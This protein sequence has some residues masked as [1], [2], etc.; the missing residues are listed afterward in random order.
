MKDTIITF[1]TA[2]LAY[3]KGFNLN[4]KGYYVPMYCVDGELMKEKLG[5]QN[6]LPET[7][8]KG[9]IIAPTQSLLQK[10]LREKHN[11][12]IVNKPILGSK[13]GYD[14]FP[15]LGWDYDVFKSHSEYNSYYMGYPI[16]DWFTATLDRFDPG[17]TLEDLN[18]FPKTYDD[19]LEKGLQEALKLIK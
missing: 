3:E 2:K 7:F 1:E 8:E 5:Y 6:E 17:D 9:F 18:V 4:D 19:A 16:G 14:S 12:F 13:N 11:I 10:W 15:I